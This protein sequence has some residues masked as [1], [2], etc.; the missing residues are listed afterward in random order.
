MSAVPRSHGGVRAG[1][2][3]ESGGNANVRK[4][5]DRGEYDG[6]NAQR[7]LCSSTCIVGLHTIVGKFIGSQFVVC[8]SCMLGLQYGVY[9]LRVELFFK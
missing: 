9:G 3:A 1:R 5:H 7:G 8:F 6:N 4:F 2:F